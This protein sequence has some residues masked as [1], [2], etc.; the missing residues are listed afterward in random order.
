VTQ[1]ALDEYRMVFF[2]T[3]GLLDSEYPELTGVALSMVD[4][5]GRS[6]DGLLRLQDV[7]HL[8]L[9]ADLVVLGACETGLGREVRG[10]GLVSLSRG[11][12]YAGASRVLASLWKVDEQ[13]TVELIRDVFRGATRDGLSYPA[14]LRRAQLRL[15]EDPRYASPYYWAAFFLQGDS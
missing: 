3:H 4:E 15:R 8:K 2:A 7:Y 13:A 1:A 14:A 9:N 11:F 5:E 10:E 6:R 12:F